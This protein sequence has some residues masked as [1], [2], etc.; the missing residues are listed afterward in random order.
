MGSTYDGKTCYTNTWGQKSNPTLP[1]FVP[2][3]YPDAALDTNGPYWSL[4]LDGGLGKGTAI[5]RLRGLDWVKA[6]WRN[7]YAL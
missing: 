1:H 6:F 5:S 3:S 4:L 7:W 2:G